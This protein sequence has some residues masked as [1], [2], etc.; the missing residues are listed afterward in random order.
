MI[1]LDPAALAAAAADERIFPR[2][3]AAQIARIAEIGRRR[4]ITRG[5]V[6]M[7]A[8]VRDIPFFVVLSG[9]IQATQADGAVDVPIATLG[10]SQFSGEANMITG[11]P[12]L[13]R[14]VVNE[15]GEVIEVERDRLLGL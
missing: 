5:E 4:P 9:E 14:A 11:R 8:G 12:A 10:A 6:L 1:G 3:T 13:V 15:S 2:L 7:E